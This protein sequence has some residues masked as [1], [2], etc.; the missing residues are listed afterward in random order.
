[1][2]SSTLTLRQEQQLEHLY[3]EHQGW[4]SSFLRKRLGCSQQAA[5]LLQDT[6]LRLLVSGRLPDSDYARPYLT[7]IAKGLVVDHFRRKRIEQAYLEELALRPEEF[8]QSPEE[9][10]Q[11]IDALI[12]ADTLLHSLPDKARRAFLLRR[13]DGL[14]YREISEQ[15]GVSVS[16]VEKYVARALQVCLTASLREEP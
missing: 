16:S 4:L 7:R 2:S 14:S 5:D 12:E 6:Y 13:V 15:L 8:V 3:R 1:M 11:L 10:L 9:Q